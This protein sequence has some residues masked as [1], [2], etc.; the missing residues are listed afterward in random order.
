M[1]YFYVYLLN[2]LPKD[3]KLW[4]EVICPV[5]DVKSGKITDKYAIRI[6]PNLDPLPNPCPCYYVEFS[7]LEE[8]KQGI[9]IFYFNYKKYF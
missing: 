3:V 5:I 9:K 2:I 8:L 7:S 4:P 1:N 6:V